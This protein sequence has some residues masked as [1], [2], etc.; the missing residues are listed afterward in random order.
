[1]NV[2]DKF[3]YK[4]S[5]NKNK[6]AQAKCLSSACQVSKNRK[7]IT[8]RLVSYNI[9]CIEKKYQ[10]KWIQTKHTVGT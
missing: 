4:T 10:Y 5:L 7:F 8:V 9:T 2:T 1:M 3:K 6:L